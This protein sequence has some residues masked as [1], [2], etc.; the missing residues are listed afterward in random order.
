MNVRLPLL[1]ATLMLPLLTGACAAGGVALPPDTCDPGGSAVLY[2][3]PN[4]AGQ[5]DM[6]RYSPANCRKS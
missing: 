5:I 4:A 6:T 3:L 2:A 1:A